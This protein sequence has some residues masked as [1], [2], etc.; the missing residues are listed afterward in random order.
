MCVVSMVMND[1]INDWQKKL[2]DWPNPYRNDGPYISP[3]IVQPPLISPEEVAEFKRLLEEARK[4]DIE[5]KQPDCASEEK[6]R[7]LKEMAA[8]LK[9]DIAFLDEI[10]P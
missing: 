1:H 3:P 4:R 10:V 7:V 6:K 8:I 9:V 2:V 5:E